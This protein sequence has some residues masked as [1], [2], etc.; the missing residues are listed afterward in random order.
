MS[1]FQHFLFVCVYLYDVLST[2]CVLGRFDRLLAISDNSR[3]K[4][5]LD[6]LTALTSLT[7][8]DMRGCNASGSIPSNIDALSQLR[9]LFMCCS[10]NIVGSL[11]PCLGNL[12]LLK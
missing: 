1:L 10:A 12:T 11:P 2:S 9:T 3:L 8:L 6:V 5:P 4:V 7:S